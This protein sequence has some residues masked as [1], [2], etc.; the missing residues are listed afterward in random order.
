M[1]MSTTSHR[2]ALAAAIAV[3]FAGAS[4]LALAQGTSGST[5]GGSSSAATASSSGSAAAM[6]AA[7]KAFAQKAA[8]GGMAEVQ[9]GQLAQ[10]KGASDQVKQFGSRMV[11]DHGK[12]NDELKQLA[13]TKGMTLPTDLDAAHKSKMAKLEKLSG[14]AFDRAY[15]TEM[16]ADHKKDVAEFQ[17]EAKSGRDSDLKGWAGKTLPTLQDHLKMAQDT[18]AA[19]K[20]TK[21]ASR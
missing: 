16:L 9:M 13:S 17:K 1:S 21:T 5:T 2:A 10:Q 15:M 11:D 8:I 14:A 6:P 12:A 20:G 7:D 3:A 18:A 4:S 19:V